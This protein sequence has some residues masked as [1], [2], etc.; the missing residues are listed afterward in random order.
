MT[1][2]RLQ[3]Y[4]AHAGIASRRAAEEII[5]QGRVKVNDT[6]IT[7]M[8]VTVNENDLVIVDGKT[9][10]I[11]EEKVYIA[12]NKPV[13]YVSTA[14]DQFGRPTVLDLVKDIE[15]RL[16]PVGRLDYDTSGLILLTNDGEFTYQLTHPKHEINKVY[17]ALVKGVPSDEEIKK[18]KT[19]LLRRRLLF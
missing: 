16:Y 2:M 11:Q 7:D 5:K 9:V 10:G 13:G 8:G 18:L 3:K 4:L 12:L 1:T 14:K 19:I 17:E 6:V 15:K